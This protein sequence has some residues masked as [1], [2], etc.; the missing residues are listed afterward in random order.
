MNL[1]KSRFRFIF[2]AALAVMVAACQPVMLDGT[3]IAL[4]F[5]EPSAQ[6]A[7]GSMAT[8]VEAEA[9]EPDPLTLALAPESTEGNRPASEIFA[10]ISPSVAF[11]E[12]EAG[13]GSG[14]LIEHKFLLS[15]AHV[16]W[17][18]N[19]VRVVFP[20]GTEHL[21]VPVYAWD[22]MADLAL[23]GPI[24]TDLPEIPLVDGAELDI[25]SDAYLVGY[26]AEVEDFPQ[27][28]IT[29]G[30]LSRLRTWEAIDYTFYQVDATIT[31]GQSGGILV[32][33]RGDV[34]GIS[35]FYFSGFGMAGSV[36]DAMP[37]LNALLGND[38]GVE[39]SN[40]PF[41]AGEGATTH[42]DTLDDSGRD[43]RQ[44][45]LIQPLE[46]EIELEATGVGRPIITVSSVNRAFF[47]YANTEEDEQSTTLSFEIEEEVPYIVTIEQPSDNENS[48]E[49]TSSHPL[50][51]YPDADNGRELTLGETVVA[52]KDTPFDSDYFE[53]DLKEGDIVEVKVDSLG[54]D[55]SVSVRYASD[56]LIEVVRDNDSGGGIFGQ[57]AQLIYE[58]KED[59]TYTF[60]VSD[61]SYG[62]SSGGYLVTIK[63][64]EDDAEITE[65]SSTRE[66]LRTRYGLMELLEIE[67]SDYSLLHPANWQEFSA[68]QCG[69]PGAVACFSN[70]GVGALIIVR[71]DLSELPKRDRN[72]EGYAD[73]ITDI[74][75]DT[76]GVDVIGDEEVATLQG[77][78]GKLLSFEAQGGRSVIY[79]YVYINEDEEEAISITGAGQIEQVDALE[80]FTEYIFN[81]FRYWEED[82]DERDDSAVHHLD[83][84]IRL[85][86]SEEITDAL[87]SYA[88]SIEIDPELAEAYSEKA[89]LHSREGEYD[90]AIESINE[91]IALRED[92]ERLI[93]TRSYY[94]WDSGDF[95]SARDDIDAAL[96]LNEEQ[97]NLYNMRALVNTFLGNYDE[98]IA[99]VDDYVA[100]NDD[101]LTPSV[102][103]TRGYVYLKMGELEKAKDDFD[104]IFDQDLRF[105]AALLGGGV[106]YFELG[107]IDMAR[108]LLEEGMERYEEA[109]IEHPDPQMMDLVEM[110]EKALKEIDK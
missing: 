104:E 15:N 42:T 109:E 87:E 89:A 62:S 21:D 103:D 66:F 86:T 41:G 79:R 74:I 45:I 26:P 110:A 48:F 17:P 20:D 31:G 95:S 32:T 19:Q 96:A 35:T 81:T 64:A 99:D 88:T 70:D 61:F 106:T 76:P 102:Q 23:I 53:I 92:D 8:E 29:N 108:E 59:D 2:M 47:D 38:T 9:D 67:G 49:L 72:L 30:I 50:I 37:R 52:A 105:I 16:V 3:P 36:A 85:Q 7:A 84:A 12:T 14:V 56:T 94:H 77:F 54:M 5:P 60:V 75:G 101:E 33:H 91:A 11:V 24:E 97:K 65:A 27:P 6:D 34:I 73:L 63:E 98:A 80:P 44:Y 28:T 69:S 51:P 93:A 107:E 55:P 71:E 40:R 58:V 25:G 82:E 90:R 100:K 1:F 83:E 46:T 13:T 18:F 4:E 78:P 22:L 39:L 43:T 68:S 10:E 57:N